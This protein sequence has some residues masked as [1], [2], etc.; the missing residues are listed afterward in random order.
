[1]IYGVVGLIVAISLVDESLVSSSHYG[2]ATGTDYELLHIKLL[3]G[4]EQGQHANTCL[5]DHLPLIHQLLSRVPWNRR[6]Q[7]DD[8]VDI[9]SC[10]DHRLRIMQISFDELNPI[11]VVAEDLYQ[12]LELIL[13][14]VSSSNL[15]VTCLLQEHLAYMS[16]DVASDAR[17]KYYLPIL[18]IAEGRRT[19]SLGVHF[20]SI[21]S[22]S[23][24]L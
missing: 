6:G 24:C 17:Q 21:Q 8:G 13:V 19:L 15:V 2:N 1:M 3:T 12:F 5:V 16:S 11:K 18:V 4:M 9:L 20:S 23:E 10:L 7:M 22:K 14:P